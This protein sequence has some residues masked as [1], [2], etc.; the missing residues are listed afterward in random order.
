MD[1]Y[2]TQAIEKLPANYQSYIINQPFNGV[3]FSSKADYLIFPPRKKS[4]ALDSSIAD[5]LVPS[6]FP[7]DTPSVPETQSLIGIINY[8]VTKFR[9]DLKF[10]AS[11]LSRYNH[12]PNKLVLFEILHVFQYIYHTRHSHLNYPSQ[13]LSYD[14]P[15]TIKT[16]CDSSFSKFG[17]SYTGFITT[18]NDTFIDAKTIRL[19][20]STISTASAELIA[21]HNAYFK[22]AIQVQE[23]LESMGFKTNPI[24]IYNDNLPIVSSINGQNNKNPS[25]GEFRNRRNELKQHIQQ[26]HLQLFHISG[27]SNISDFLTKRYNKSQLEQLH[28]THPLMTQLITIVKT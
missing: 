23:Q 3:P 10:S 17:D 18:V 7:F 26:N 12:Y 11:I 21:I 27:K 16:Y 15:I 5:S 6:H 1:Q 20:Q 2:I 25:Y 8:I 14:T 13:Q 28:F 24:Q 4:N 9:F 19:D 22:S